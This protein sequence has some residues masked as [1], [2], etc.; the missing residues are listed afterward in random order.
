[1]CFRPLEP[2][3]I[4]SD[5]QRQFQA[6]EIFTFQIFNLH[7]F[8]LLSV[9]TELTESRFRLN[10]KPY[11]FALVVLFTLG[12]YSV[13]ISFM[14]NIRKVKMDP[15]DYFFLIWRNEINND[16]IYQLY[17]HNS[18]IRRVSADHSENNSK[19]H[20]YSLQTFRSHS[21]CHLLKSMINM[22][23]FSK[24]F[25]FKF[26]HS[27]NVVRKSNTPSNTVTIGLNFSVEKSHPQRRVCLMY[28]RY[29][30]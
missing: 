13:I 5:L 15:Y 30:P 19:F 24:S 23:L 4:C 21:Q 16:E 14:E 20:F 11:L 1:M 12:S 2:T 3:G 26:I 7:L 27:G 10:I 25:R 29:S 6:V 9:H 8:R 17:Y 22:T 18:S 28:V